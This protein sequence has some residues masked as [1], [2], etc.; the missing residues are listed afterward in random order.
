MKLH[1]QKTRQKRTSTVLQCTVIDDGLVKRTL[2][3]RS[4]KRGDEQNKVR[5]D[6][7]SAMLE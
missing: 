3:L 1:E 5:N 6:L 2:V 7:R 4:C